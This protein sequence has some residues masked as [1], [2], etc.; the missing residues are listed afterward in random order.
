VNQQVGVSQWVSLG[1]FN[2]QGSYRVMLRNATS[3]PHASRSVVANAIRL[4]PIR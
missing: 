3:G 1:V 2:F 4:T